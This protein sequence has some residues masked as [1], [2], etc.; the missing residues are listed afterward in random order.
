M[1]TTNMIPIELNEALHIFKVMEKHST[2]CS[3]EFQLNGQSNPFIGISEQPVKAEYLETFSGEGTGDT[4]V[5]TLG[6][7]EFAFELN[8][9]VSKNITE[10]Q[11]TLCLVKDGY[12]AWFSSGEM[13]EEGIKEASN[14]KEID[15]DSLERYPVEINEY[16]RQL[17]EFVRSVDFEDILDAT[18]G[19]YAE[20]EN[21]KTKSFKCRPD[22]REGFLVRAERLEKLAELLGLSNAYYRDHIYPEGQ[23]ND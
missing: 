8:F 16:E 19:L 5:V 9:D 3:L 4:V 15:W 17:I 11:I 13:S 6:E 10:S 22:Q 14:Y 20:A 18:T 7:S 12:A 2:P 1:T 21:A 23:L